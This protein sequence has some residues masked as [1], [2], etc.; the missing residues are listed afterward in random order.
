MTLKSVLSLS[1][2]SWLFLKSL[3]KSYKV[4]LVKLNKLLLIYFGSRCEI[5]DETRI[6]AG[7]NY[8]KVPICQNRLIFCN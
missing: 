5:V 4:L 6:F 1:I 3:I 7:K 8:P 2:L